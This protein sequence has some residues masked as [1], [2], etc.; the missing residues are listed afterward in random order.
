MIKNKPDFSAESKVSH[1]AEPKTSRRKFIELL[2]VGIAVG[3]LS[4]CSAT[5][6]SVKRKSA[7]NLKS[8]EK[9]LLN[10]KNFPLRQIYKDGIILGELFKLVGYNK[11]AASG[12]QQEFLNM[13][14]RYLGDNGLYALQEAFS[15]GNKKAKV[16]HIIKILELQVALLNRHVQMDSE[17]L[18]RLKKSEKVSRQFVV[19]TEFKIQDAQRHKVNLISLK[20]NIKKYHSVLSDF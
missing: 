9:A 5:V 3:S 15:Q 18:N 13:T 4:A 20:N 19:S 17:L 12:R 7:V 16:G 11:L 14:K 10:I 1:L 2:T 6:K 8:P